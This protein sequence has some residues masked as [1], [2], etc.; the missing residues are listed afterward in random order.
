MF[1]HKL[2]EVA[3]GSI[4]LV[5]A[6]VDTA[7]AGDPPPAADGRAGLGKGIM[8]N[9]STGRG[10]IPG[11]FEQVKACPD[12]AG[13]QV[14]LS[15]ADLEPEKGKHRWGEIDRLL[16][17]YGKIG[18]QVALKFTA[19]SGKVMSDSQL[20]KGKGR[21]GADVEHRNEATPAWLFDDPHVRRF[22]GFA[23]P[24][25]KVPL[26]PVFWDK[27][28]QKHLG[29][30][31]AV[32]ARRYDGDPRIEYIRMGGW[33]VGTNEPSF[34]GGATEYLREQLAA[35]GEPLPA[36]RKAHLPANSRYSEAVTALID[37][38]HA[39]FKKT[40]LAATIHFPKE[41]ADR[42]SF[43]QVMN[44]HCAKYRV[45][46]LNTGLN[47]RDKTETRKAYRAWHDSQRCKVGW[48]GI[49]HLGWEGNRPAQQRP[50]DLLEQ[51]FRQGIGDD[52]APQLSPASRVSYLVMGLDSLREAKA[53]AWASQRLVP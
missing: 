48:G 29:D 2:I 3:A 52:G 32:M 26:Y 15:W 8:I 35:Q 43:E 5:I 42:G 11:A 44:D 36:G 21:A 7:E 41:D 14:S 38:W 30:F 34:Y 27:G 1:F 20:A 49:T 12:V 10:V 4:L 33:Q 16:D 25:G 51:A 13:V 50:P 40:R 18:K 23:T 31:L 22:G 47:E 28:Y 19:V 45:T 9:I 39:N 6:A 46:I 53:L 24:K 37:L 17:Q